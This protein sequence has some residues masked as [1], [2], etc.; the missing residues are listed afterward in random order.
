MKRNVLFIM[1][2]ML[3]GGAEKVLI[4]ILKNFDYTKY[5]VSLLL[6]CKEGP[7]INDIPDEV[8][9]IYLH[10]KNLWIERFYRYMIMLHCKWLVY[11]VLF[12]MEL[13]RTPF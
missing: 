5:N 8:E 1:P 9:L 13:E 2:A 12:I 3:N 11:Q 7:Y 6:E 4:D 10:K